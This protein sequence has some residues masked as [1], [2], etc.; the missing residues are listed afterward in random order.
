MRWH[1]GR[2]GDQEFFVGYIS[3]FLDLDFRQLLREALRETE[4]SWVKL[5]WD[6]QVQH[7]SSLYS[8]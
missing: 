3:A 4:E 1:C 7:S 8:P 2:G 6:S 5:L